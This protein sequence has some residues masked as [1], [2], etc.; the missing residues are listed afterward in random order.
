MAQGLD[1]GRGRRQG[2]AGALGRQVLGPH[3]QGHLVAD[4]G[5][6]RLHRRGQDGARAGAHRHLA[7][8]GLHHLGGDQVHLGAADELGHEA[9]GRPL[10]QLH[11]RAD[12]FDPSAV[13]HHDPVGQGHGLHL[14][15]GDVDHGRAQPLVQRRE[16]IAHAHPERRVQVRQGLVE[17]EDLG[18]TH[19]GPA[20]GHALALAARQ[21]LGLAVQ[22]VADV[23]HLG[24][25]VDAAP[26][27]GLVDLRQRQ[28]EAH[29]L[30]HRHVRIE[31]IGLEHH[32]D[33][34]IRG[35][36][37]RDVAPADLDRAAV[38]LLQPG[39]GAQQGGLAAARGPDEHDELAVGD[40]QVDALQHLDRAEALP[41]PAQPNA[42]HPSPPT[43]VSCLA[44]A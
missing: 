24:G 2:A 9:I 25:G 42:R 36:Q 29:V 22:I 3:A 6:V 26:D 33:A 17:Q 28:G 8:A 18:F 32:G 5:A 27:V 34:A 15:M 31:R 41:D 1:E 21:G 7:A 43:P 44:S 20:D 4:L 11:R 23:Q 37:P 19:D 14:V 39:D 38:Q 35:R 13:Q 12:L 10:I 40:L 30:A 16:L